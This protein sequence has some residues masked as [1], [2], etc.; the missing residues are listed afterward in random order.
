L[1]L[2]IN[3]VDDI[4]DPIADAFLHSLIPSNFRAMIGS[5]VNQFSEL[6]G[7]GGVLLFTLMLGTQQQA[8]EEAIPD[9]VS[10]FSG[11]EV[12]RFVLPETWIGLN[13]ADAAIVMF[14]LIGLLAVPILL[15]FP[16]SRSLYGVPLNSPEALGLVKETQ[17]ASVE[18]GQRRE[19]PPA[20]APSTALRQQ[21]LSTKDRLDELLDTY[22]QGEQL[23]W[24]VSA[25]PF[26]I[27]GHSIALLRRAGPALTNFFRVANNLLAEHTWLRHRLEKTFTPH[28]RSL[29]SSQINA[30]PHL[31]RPDVV[32]DE[33]WQPK[34]VELEITVGARADTAI[35]A[36]HYG[37]AS[38]RSLLRAYAD[39]IKSFAADGKH[40]AFV[41][42]PHPFFQ[43]LPDDAK[44]FAGQLR[45]LGASNITVLTDENLGGL[46]FDGDNL[47]L[48][49]RNG[50]IQPIH[51][52][53]RFIDIYE[54]AELQHPG[55]AAIFDA[56][57]KGK[58]LDIN[59]IRQNL[60][61]KDWM[62]LFWDPRLRSLWREGL[63][64]HDDRILR[65]MIPE[66]WI[67][68][69]GASV[70]L[71]N[72]HQVPVEELSHLKPEFRKFVIKESGTSTT[73]SGAQAF[74]VL[75]KMEPEEIHTLLEDIFASG[76]EYILQRLIESPRI[77][78]TAID[79]ET[80]Q[81]H[82]QND[83]RLKLSPFYV[84]GRL[85]DIRFIASNKK[86]AV[87]DEACVV[88]I[89]QY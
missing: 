58:I 88:S 87:N 5:I 84:N 57:V 79:P 52:I 70:P 85:T 38:E 62:S 61:E 24:W 89:V 64:E 36:K 41:T 77:S 37:L 40:V 14:A 83:A 3:L 16:W 55:M 71:E 28:Y 59:T 17:D 48:H 74:Y 68:E 60:D 44:S 54:I 67:I 19:E 6:A 63:G 49:S 21:L 78:F 1:F 9:L 76:V 82:I 46:R 53:D 56:Y 45:E 22:N 75:T 34:L 39:L 73:A 80:D 86:Y 15:G 26:R 29:N 23:S 30:V 4:W 72:G 51:V 13:V 69:R 35:M 31:I 32:C 20:A 81:I 47:L 18:G 50:D 12:R 66:T 27:P 10:A 8:L 33:N 43:D 65:Q 25:T 11:A 42:A 7:I 2:F